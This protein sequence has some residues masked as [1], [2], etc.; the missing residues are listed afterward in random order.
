MTPQ[1]FTDGLSQM[2]VKIKNFEEKDA[3]KM[4]GK[5]AADFFTDNFQRQGFL[6]RGLRAWPEVKRRKPKANGRPYTPRETTAAGRRILFGQTRNLSRSIDYDPQKG[7]VIVYSDVHYAP[8]HNEGTDKLPKR[9]FIGDSAELDKLV[10][11][12]LERK[13]KNII[14]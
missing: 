7:H 10:I 1:Q 14:K 11:S 4:A 8:Y 12:E 9:Q 13:L 6:S 2:A 3:P 5:T